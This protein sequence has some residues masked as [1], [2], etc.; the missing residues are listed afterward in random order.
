MRI[1]YSKEMLEERVKDVSSFAGLA[2]NLGLSPQGSNTTQLKIKCVKLGVDTSHFTG[3][4]HSR[5]QI[6]NNRT[7]PEKL[8]TLGNPSNPR[9]AGKRLTRA[10]VQIG[11]ELKCE[12]CDQPPVWNRKPLTLQVD[13]RN[14]RYWDNRPENV[15]FVCP[16][17]HTQTDTF[18]S[19]NINNLGRWTCWQ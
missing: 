11:R 8:L 9:I 4:A 1:N 14:G 13:H 2:R 17:C 6:A 15:R 10:L 19:K 12:E 16:N 5:G 18:C 3:S 7:L